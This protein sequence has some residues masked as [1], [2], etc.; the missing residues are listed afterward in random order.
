MSATATAREWITGWT[1]ETPPR[2]DCSF[3][4]AS[5]E[6]EQGRWAGTQGMRPGAGRG[7]AVCVAAGMR[8]NVP[9]SR[10][11]TN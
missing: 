6:W 11:T 10:L 5:G 7:D 4:D 2:I 3:I 1:L 9:T 8:H